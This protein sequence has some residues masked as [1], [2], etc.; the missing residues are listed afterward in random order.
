MNISITVRGVQS[1]V[2]IINIIT[3]SS[4]SGSIL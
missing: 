1:D 3:I 4:V 2:F